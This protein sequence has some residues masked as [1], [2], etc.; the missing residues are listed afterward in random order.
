MLEFNRSENIKIILDMDSTKWSVRII[1]AENILA[2]IEGKENISNEIKQ[3]LSDVGYDNTKTIF[4]D[5]VF[6]GSL[7][8]TASA[9]RNITKSIREVSEE[10]R[11]M[12]TSETDLS[13]GE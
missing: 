4:C 3:V 1:K 6:D 5:L 11:Y 10:Y 13:I 12:Y 2:T 9:Y 8:G 7:P